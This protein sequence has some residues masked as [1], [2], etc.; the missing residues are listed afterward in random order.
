[1]FMVWLLLSSSCYAKDL[2]VYGPAF[3]ILERDAYEWLIN[4]RLND[5]SVKD[6]IK[7]IEDEMTKMAR[8]R[9][10]NPIGAKL[11]KVKAYSK[12]E[13]TL[14][15][16]LPID[17]KDA[18][19]KVIFKRGTSV[20]FEDVVPESKM[21]LIFIDGDDEVQVRFALNELN[22]N[23]FTKIVLVAGRPINLMRDLNI[24]LYFDQGQALVNKFNIYGVPSRIHREKSNLIIEELVIND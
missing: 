5:M 23:K 15:N 18:K 24:N 11:P 3:N 8:H 7:E 4:E 1:M 17:I 21:T 20:K 9:I 19:G 14:N 16:E 12:R 2:G 13:I 6:R 22:I 10:E